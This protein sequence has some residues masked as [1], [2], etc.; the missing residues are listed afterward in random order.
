MW[1]FLLEIT[2]DCLLGAASSYYHRRDSATDI[3]LAVGG[4][5]VMLGTLFGLLWFIDSC[6]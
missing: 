2:F 6:K 5:V 1:Q 4:V 3:A